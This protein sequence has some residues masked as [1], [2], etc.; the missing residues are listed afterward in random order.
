[1]V[2]V[3]FSRKNQKCDPN[4]GK[5]HQPGSCKGFLEKVNPQQELDSGCDVLQDAQEAEG[6]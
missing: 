3:T 5:A 6:N 1:M 2:E 4:Y